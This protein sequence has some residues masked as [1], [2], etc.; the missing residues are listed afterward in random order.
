M[1][2]G[3]TSHFFLCTS[4]VFILIIRQHF[5]FSVG[6]YPD[7]SFGFLQFFCLFVCF[8]NITGLRQL[9]SFLPTAS[10]QTLINLGLKTPSQ[11]WMLFSVWTGTLGGEYLLWFVVCGLW[12]PQSCKGFLFSFLSA[13]SDFMWVLQIWLHTYIFEFLKPYRH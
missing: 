1:H 12:I 10:F 11:F 6:S 8:L 2:F 5:F 3:G 4:F 9:Q 7:V 13:V